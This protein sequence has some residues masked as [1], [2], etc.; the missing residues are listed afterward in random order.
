VKKLEVS[1]TTAG[2]EIRRRAPWILLA[3]VAGIVMVLVGQ[4]FEAAFS[5]NIELAFF[6]PVIVY[7]S[8]SIGTETLALFVRE[9]DLKRMKLRRLFLRESTVGISLGLLSGMPMGLFAYWWLGD[10]RLATTVVIAMTANGFVAVLTGML[11]PITFAR[12]GRDPALGS[13]EITTA[14]S[15]NVSMLTYLLVA[16]LILF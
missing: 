14:L 7:M 3:L 13:D 6:V 8:D 2:N 12:L 15:D 4:S 9:V 16:T 5:R 1:H 10:V 11:A